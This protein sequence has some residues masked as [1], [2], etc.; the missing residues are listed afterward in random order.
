MTHGVYLILYCFLLAYT[1]GDAARPGFLISMICQDA[2]PLGSVCTFGSMC[3]VMTHR[4]M[5]M[6]MA[7]P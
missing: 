2:I 4:M 1:W 5:C 7:S 6:V 3:S